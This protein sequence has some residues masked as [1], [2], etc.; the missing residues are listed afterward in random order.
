LQISPLSHDNGSR[1]SDKVDNHA[2]RHWVNWHLPALSWTPEEAVH[3]SIGPTVRVPRLVMK[4]IRPFRAHFACPRATDCLPGNMTRIASP[5]GVKT[6]LLDAVIEGA[7]STRFKSVLLKQSLERIDCLARRNV[8]GPKPTSPGQISRIVGPP[9]KPRISKGPANAV[10]FPGR[11][12]QWLHPAFGRDVGRDQMREMSFRSKPH[13]SQASLAWSGSD[14]PEAGSSRAIAA[15]AQN[16]S[17]GRSR[18]S[19]RR[20]GRAAGPRPIT[21]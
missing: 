17:S 2:R 6:D 15:K 3:L 8:L 14:K 20:R 19:S 4:G 7:V 13:A 1:R 9:A 12:A 16:Q 18:S 5:V 21:C 11:A 10:V